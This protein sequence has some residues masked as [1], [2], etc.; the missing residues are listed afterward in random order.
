MGRD[1]VEEF[2]GLR[3]MRAAPPGLKK[4]D[5]TNDPQHVT[6]TFA[7]RHVLLDLVRK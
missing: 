2:E 5:F 6:A 3:E 4:Q 7:G 1:A